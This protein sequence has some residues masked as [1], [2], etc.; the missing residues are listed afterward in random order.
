VYTLAP[1][2]V[3]E[4]VLWAGTDDGLIQR[5][6]DGGRTWSDVTPSDLRSRPWA[7]V[8]LI[9]A[10]HFDART[11]YAAVNTFRLDDLRPHIYRTHDGGATW[12][13]IVAG[14]DS[15]A[16]VNVVRE[17]PKRRGLLF[18]GSETQV[19]FSIDDGDNWQPLRLN[20][21]ASSIRDLVIK[22]DDLVVGTH[23]R[24]IW[25]LDDIT[26]LRQIDSA[27]VRRDAVLFRPQVAT[28]WGWSLYPDTPLPPD[29]PAGQN[30]PDGAIINYWLRTMSATPVTLE[31]L[32][33]GGSVVRR[34]ASTDTAQPPADVGNV[35]AYWLRPTQ[36]LAATAGM[37]RFVWD[38]RHNPP[39]ALTPTYPLSAIVHDTPREPRGVWVMPGTYTIRLTADGKSTTQPLVVRMDPR[40]TTP[41]AALARQ[42]AVSLQL[43]AAMKQAYDAVRDSASGPRSSTQVALRRLL[44]EISE[45]YSIAQNAD[46]APTA[47]ASQAIAERLRALPPLLA[48]R[49]EERATLPPGGGASGAAPPAPQAPSP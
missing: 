22:D 47:Q 16:I 30:P 32:D 8:S 36:V 18:A 20:M 21:P 46:A 45:L 25:I 39:P 42:L 29:E 27:T 2:H 43:S 4:R 48:R 23:G 15:G 40:V 31:I 11:A 5:T 37:H 26:P 12:R 41:R 38:L 34:Y 24:S 44:G 9:D 6:A 13:E 7:K 1:S 17:D 3:S 14:I 33:G 10:S 35:P 49:K 28:R 19:W